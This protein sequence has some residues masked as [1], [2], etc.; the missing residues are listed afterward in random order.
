MTT[1]DNS[2]CNN[3]H[4]NDQC[5]EGEMI[6]CDNYDQLTT[7]QEYDDMLIQ[8]YIDNNRMAY[9]QEWQ[10]YMDYI[11]NDNWRNGYDL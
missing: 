7:T 1:K 5:G 6:E 4:W 2:I 9:R 10:D 3:C 8:D 11:E